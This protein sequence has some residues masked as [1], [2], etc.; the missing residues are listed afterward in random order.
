VQSPPSD[1]GDRIPKSDGLAN[2]PQRTECSQQIEVVELVVV[3]HDRPLEFGGVYPSNKVL[4]VPCDEKGGISDCV[5]A[6]TD[7]ALFDE[8]GGCTDCLGHFAHAHED[9]E[10]AATKCGNG[11]PVVDVAEFCLRREDADVVELGEQLALH[12]GA[13][14]VLRGEH[15]E[16]V[17]IRAE[18][19]AE[20]V[21]SGE[22]S[23]G[24]RRCRGTDLW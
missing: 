9:G 5:G 15:G 18:C 19:A 10:A 4:H 13:K 24:Q 7:V 8:L 3:S 11:E 2:P 16:A 23:G 22:M 12:L 6:D 20:L 1:R 17:C 14:G 21:V